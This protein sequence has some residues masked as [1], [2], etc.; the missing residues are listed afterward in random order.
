MNKHNQIQSN[1]WDQEADRIFKI[2]EEM[3][4]LAK[5]EIEDFFDYINL[6]SN[7]D[8]LEI[9]CG[10]GRFTFP[11]LRKGNRVTG[12]D[13]SD[14]SLELLKRMAQKEGLAQN[15]KVKNIDFTK[16]I[17]KNQFDLVVIGNVIHHFIPERKQVIINNIVTALKPGGKVAIWEPNAYCPMYLPWYAILELSGKER[18]IWAAEKGVFK[19]RFSEIKR[20]L[21]NAGI[22]NVELKRHTLIPLRLDQY[23]KN[24][25]K[26]NKQ[27]LKI[28]VFRNMSAYLWIKGV[29]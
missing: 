25:G 13:V 27:L 18:G 4:Q 6:G 5:K 12:T 20:L 9:G 24:V 10:A 15:L 19:S 1:Y 28:P 11:M 16:K 7:Q 26:I 17:Y 21:E 29:K 3:S 23:I 22:K 14:K 2:N 8:I